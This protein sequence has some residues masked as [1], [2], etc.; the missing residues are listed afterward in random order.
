[1]HMTEIA[2]YSLNYSYCGGWWL[3][4]DNITESVSG[5]EPQFARCK[6]AGL[7][8]SKV[9]GLNPSA[10]KPGKRDG[11]LHPPVIIGYNWLLQL[12]SPKSN[13]WLIFQHVCG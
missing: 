8:E 13:K 12:V 7:S 5:Q 1:M 4:V 3:S 10:A 2:L 6:N 9:Q 11:L